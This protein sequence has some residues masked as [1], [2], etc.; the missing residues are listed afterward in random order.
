M[1]SLTLD[2]SS[3][4]TSRSKGATRADRAGEASPTGIWT[5]ALRHSAATIVFAGLLATVLW[6][7]V[8]YQIGRERRDATRNA[9]VELTNLTRAFAE[10]TSRTLEGADQAI[11]FVR[12]EYADHGKALDIGAYLKQKAIID[13]TFHLISIIGPDGYVSNSSQPFQRIDLRDRE[14]FKVHVQASEDRLFVSKPVLGRVSGKWSI[15]LTRRIAETDGTFGGVVVLSLTPEY[16]TRFYSEVDLGRHGAITLVGYDGV[17]RAR[18]TPDGGQGAQ[19]ISANPLFQEAMK[20]KSGTLIAT[21]RIDG[22][23]RVWSFR[24]LDNYGLLVFT[25]MGMSDVMAEPSQRR[26]SYLFGASLITIVMA[27]FVAGL[28]RRARLQLELMRQLEASNKQAQAASLMKSKFLASVSHELRT[29]LNGILGYAELLAQGAS[30]AESREFGQ[31][32][33]HSAEHLHSLVN[34]IL[35]LAKIESG[36]M[37]LHPVAVPLAE[38]LGKA[39]ALGAVQ[40]RGRGIELILDVRASAPALVTTDVTRLTQVLN[41]LLDNAI[42]FTDHGTVTLTASGDADEAVI[43]VAD[44]GCGIPAAVLDS[45]FTRFHATTT[46]FVHPAQGA[47]L[48]LPL[49]Y[50]LT[51]LLGGSLTLI[52]SPGTG[53]TVTLRLPVGGPSITSADDADATA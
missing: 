30:D 51:E 37:R 28:V 23:E 4:P 41:N 46:E 49:A 29:P 14:H 5:A 32:I 45:V 52:S 27:G 53:T 9:Q 19:D 22:V 48:G 15:Q 25:G 1:N 36:K 40:A 18:A 24:A 17:V 7:A 34:T 33:H 44:T 11:R 43:E 38:L 16:L 42:K 12:N 21:S 13:S 31:F 47:G 6:V 3:S 35:D 2:P 20:R 26:T 10:H 39:Q 8:V 50:E